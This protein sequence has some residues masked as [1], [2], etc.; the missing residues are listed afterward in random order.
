MFLYIYVYKYKRFDSLNV[1]KS[2][3]F[4]KLSNLILFFKY[5]TLQKFENVRKCYYYNFYYIQNKYQLLTFKRKHLF[6]TPTDITVLIVYTFPLFAFL[7]LS[8]I[9]HNSE[10]CN[11]RCFLLLYSSIE[12][13]IILTSL[14]SIKHYDIRLIHTCIT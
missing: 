2:I 3:F 4:Q 13:S 1:Q 12:M 6:L 11:I 5:F 14:F 8:K 10:I 9:F 7:Y